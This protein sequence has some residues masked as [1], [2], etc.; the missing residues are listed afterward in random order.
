MIRRN[1]QKEKVAKKVTFALALITHSGESE[2][3]DMVV[4]TPMKKVTEI[5]E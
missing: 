5:Y 2:R 4:T 3:E 1:N